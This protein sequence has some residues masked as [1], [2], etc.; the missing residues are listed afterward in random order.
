MAGSI[1][2]F[3]GKKRPEGRI[4]AHFGINAATTSLI[5][6][7]VRS[8]FTGWSPQNHPHNRQNNNQINQHIEHGPDQALVGLRVDTQA[9]ADFRARPENDISEGHNASLKQFL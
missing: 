9:L 5:C 2:D 1:A 8:I 4:T 6:A 7:A 3:I